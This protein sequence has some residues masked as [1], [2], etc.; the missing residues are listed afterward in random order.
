MLRSTASLPRFCCVPMLV[1][2][3]GTDGGTLNLD[4]AGRPDFPNSTATTLRMITWGAQTT[5]QSHS[6]DDWNVT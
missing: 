6:Q 3:S 2:L 5:T 4:F 1:K